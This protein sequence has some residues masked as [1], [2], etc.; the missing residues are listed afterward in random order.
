[1]KYTVED[2]ER[3]IRDLIESS[4]H[5]RIDLIEDLESRGLDNSIAT[6][7]VDKCLKDYNNKVSIVKPQK[8]LLGL[9]LILGA[10]PVAIFI[11][12]RCH[13]AG[14]SLTNRTAIIPIGMIITGIIAIKRANRIKQIK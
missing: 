8:Y 2:Y 1:M 9:F 12:W 3:Y 11:L 14:V 4:A 7:I 13:E 5:S 6:A 10:L